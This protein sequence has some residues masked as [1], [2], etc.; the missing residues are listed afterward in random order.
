MPHPAPHNRHPVNAP[1]I[2]ETCPPG[3]GRSTLVQS[4]RSSQL[5]AQEQSRSDNQAPL[6][7]Q[8]VDN[9]AKYHG[10][11]QCSSGRQ[12]TPSG[13]GARVRRHFEWRKQPISKFPG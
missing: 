5:W 1:A 12:P 2:P 10:R 3:E 7:G 6:V 8:Q 9:E 13:I 11:Y 4:S